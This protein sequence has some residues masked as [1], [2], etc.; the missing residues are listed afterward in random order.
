[1]NDLNKNQSG[2]T[3]IELMIVVAII[4]ILAAI[5]IPAYQ[6]YSIRTQVS[7]GLSL[8]NSAKVAVSDFYMSTGG[9]PS[10]NS[11]AGL[12]AATSINGDYTAQVSVSNNLIQIQY[13]NSAHAAINGQTLTLTGAGSDGS[14]TWTCGS[15]G[16][17]ADS[18]LPSVCR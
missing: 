2:F 7:E 18:N 9:W 10:N 17:I 5:A 1:M 4:G 12:A 16:A 8:T 15:G 14:V 6:S 3:L 13:G 11:A